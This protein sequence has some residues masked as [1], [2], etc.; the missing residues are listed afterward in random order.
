[1]TADLDIVIVTFNSAHVID[2]LL[3]SIPAALGELRGEVIIVDN[4]STDGTP[5][6]IAD[7]PNCRIIL[8]SNDGY[9]AGINKGT[10]AGTGSAI[11]VLNPDV[12]LAPDSIPPLRTA[13]D[14]PSTGIVAPRIH[15]EY[16]TLYRSLRRE[17]TLFRAMGLNRTGIAAFSEYV[18]S[19]E[20]YLHAG[21]VDWALGA[22]L[23]TS[24]ECFDAVGGWDES[25]FLY[26]EE[27]DFCL[28][29]RDLGFLTRYEPA[30][31]SVHLG[32]QSGQNE[33][34]HSMQIIN[35]VRLYRRRHGP[36]TS[37]LYYCL[38]ALS[39]LTWA[40][41]SGARS[42]FALATLVRPSLRPAELGCSDRLMPR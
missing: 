27:T 24:R 9:S 6:L 30:S 20:T 21:T 36:L 2:H 31:M 42:R 13:L 16:G 15:S 22:V 33:K 4:G 26:S 41:R 14:L 40:V 37:W 3:D 7:R 35:R 12:R 28:R 29:A 25:Y 1:V 32:G 18:H 19:P 10:R 17:P 8:S 38:T 34:T 5:E 23:L 11:L 39:E